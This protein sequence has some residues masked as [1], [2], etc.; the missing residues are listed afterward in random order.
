MEIVFAVMNKYYDVLYFSN[1]QNIVQEQVELTT[2]N[3]QKTEKLIDLGL[4]AESDLL[5]MKAQEATEKHNLVLAQ[6]Q[7][8]QALLS[9]K[10]LMN[11][12]ANKELSIETEETSDFVGTL[13]SPDEVYASALGHIPSIQRANL[14][15]EASQK[16]LDIARGNL[17]PRLSLGASV[18]TNYADSRREHINPNDPNSD[19]HI[20]PFK[21]QWNQNMALCI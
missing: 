6:N 3:L 8:E 7:Y 10:N 1:L 15:M 21:S 12:P 14:D 11:F 5:E 13:F 20:V 4:K 18:Y 9:L 17:M 19:L 16:Q 2:L